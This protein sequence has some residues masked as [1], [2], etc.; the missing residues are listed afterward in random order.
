MTQKEL[1]YLKKKAHEGLD[2]PPLSGPTPGIAITLRY[3]IAK[4]DDLTERIDAIDDELSTCVFPE[5]GTLDYR[6][7]A[8]D[9]E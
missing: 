9:E 3:I 6:A 5:D 1:K 2:H 4:L 7:Y 8:K